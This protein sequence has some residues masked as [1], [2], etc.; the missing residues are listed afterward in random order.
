VKSGV[1]HA[2]NSP[3]NRSDPSNQ[4]Q[5]T[6]DAKIRSTATNQLMENRRSFVGSEKSAAPIC[7]SKIGGGGHREGA[8]SGQYRGDRE[9]RGSDFFAKSEASGFLR[10]LDVVL[11][12]ARIAKGHCLYF[13]G[14]YVVNSDLGSDAAVY[15]TRSLP[16]SRSHSRVR[17]S[18][19]TSHAPQPTPSAPLHDLSS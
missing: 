14:I 5:F 13:L 1:S 8:G 10:S 2:H 19:G 11:R 9:S 4:S 16:S 3:R 12:F 15:T 18:C 17:Y 6:A 7:D